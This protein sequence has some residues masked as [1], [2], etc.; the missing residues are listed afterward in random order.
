MAQKKPQ[1]QAQPKASPAPPTKI[2]PPG[3]R[4]IYFILGL[5]SFPLALVAL[6]VILGVSW[7]LFA[8]AFDL[9]KGLI[10]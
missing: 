2:D 8:W 1:P 6:G 3:K 7:R 4:V 10:F 5:A 9:G